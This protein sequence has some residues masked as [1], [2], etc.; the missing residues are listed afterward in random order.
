MSWNTSYPITINCNHSSIRNIAKM[1]RLTT[2]LKI[3]LRQTNGSVSR[4]AYCSMYFLINSM[5]EKPTDAKGNNNE[6]L[7]SI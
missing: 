7:Q 4:L 1:I 6:I 2:S 5:N 3:Y